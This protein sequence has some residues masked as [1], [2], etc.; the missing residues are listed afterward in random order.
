MTV[1]ITTVIVLLL[2]AAGCTEQA[3]STMRA[4][5]DL[6]V[7][8]E[9]R[10]LHIAQTQFYQRNNR[11]GTLEE[12]RGAGMINDPALAAGKKHNYT[13][14]VVSANESGYAFRADP[15]DDSKFSYRHFYI[16]QTGLVRANH[17]KPAGPNDPPCVM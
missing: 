1:R 6:A 10:N 8:A 16:D 4:A 12:L 5:G 11:Y 14:T 17:T 3:V 15:E 9:L 7:V 2:I 13:F